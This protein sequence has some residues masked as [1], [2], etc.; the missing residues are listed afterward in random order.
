MRRMTTLALLLGLGAC[1][2][3]TPS[4]QAAGDGP[5]YVVFFQEWS[6]GLDGSANRVI[7]AAAR[8]AAADPMAPVHVL[9]AADMLGSPQA[10]VYLSQTRAQ[11]VTDGL[12]RDGV[13]Q[14]RIVQDARGS[15][16][17]VGG[18]VES[19]RVTITIGG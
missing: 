17:P 6:A 18:N 12:V 13:A 7:T 16:Q 14:S 1:S 19:R 10:N 9:G 8:A 3:V 15:L 5:R 11:V 2:T 4:P